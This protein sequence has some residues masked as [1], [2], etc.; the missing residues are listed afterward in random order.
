MEGVKKDVHKQVSDKL[1]KMGYPKLAK[2]LWILSNAR[3]ACDYDIYNA[4][5]GKDAQLMKKRS[6][7]LIGKL[8][9]ILSV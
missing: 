3:K 7:I 2:D 5:V 9:E 8:Q 4:Y 6:I 1:D